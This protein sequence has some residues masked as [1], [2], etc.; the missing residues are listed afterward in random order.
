MGHQDGGWGY[1]GNL[2]FTCALMAFYI[3]RWSRRQVY[4]RGMLL[5]TMM[6]D[7]EMTALCHKL[8]FSLRR[9]TVFVGGGKG[10]HADDDERMLYESS[11]CGYVCGGQQGGSY[12][13]SESY[14]DG[15]GQQ[16]LSP[17][18]VMCSPNLERIIKIIGDAKCVFSALGKLLS[19]AAWSLVTRKCATPESDAKVSQTMTRTMKVREQLQ[20]WVHKFG[21]FFSFRLSSV[22]AE[23]DPSVV[24]LAHVKLS[25]T[26]LTRLTRLVEGT[27]HC[28]SLLSEPGVIEKLPAPTTPYPLESSRNGLPWPSFTTTKGIFLQHRVR[29]ERFIP[30]SP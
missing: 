15:M 8:L 13:T 19:S 21:K 24:C 30:L 29:N 7:L 25:V 23:V 9:G 22:R 28:R 10:N 12:K 16:E 17:C 14:K 2:L 27:S 18:Y 20:P 3:A 6:Y 5:S 26:R 11:F 1:G 4:T